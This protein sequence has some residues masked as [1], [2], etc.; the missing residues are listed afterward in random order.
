MSTTACQRHFA[1]AVSLSCAF[2]SKLSMA[3]CC[4]CLMKSPLIIGSDV[5]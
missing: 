2:L 3:L 1:C 4:R 5:S